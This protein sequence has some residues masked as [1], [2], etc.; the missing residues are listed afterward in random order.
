M[1]TF[2]LIITIL[3]IV[4]SATAIASAQNKTTHPI[5]IIRHGWHTGLAVKINDIPKHLIPE[6]AHFHGMRF[7]E[8][9]WG[10]KGFYQAKKITIPLTLKAMILPTESIIHMVGFSYPVEKFFSKSEVIRI[11]VKRKNFLILLTFIH[12]SFERDKNKTLLP[13]RD[14]IY[15]YSWF[16]KGSGYYHIFRT[17]NKWTAEALQKAN[18]PVNTYYVA[19]AESLMSQIRNHQ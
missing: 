11:N 7:L 6:K 15:G 14:G 19:N 1:R 10:D 12:N 9:G 5:Y 8:I 2:Q 4:I 16:Y 3:L 18:I 13:L 17:C